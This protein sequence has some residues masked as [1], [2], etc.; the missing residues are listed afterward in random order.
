MQNYMMSNNYSN[1]TVFVAPLAIALW[2]FIQ[3]N[4]F[5]ATVVVISSQEDNETTKEISS[6]KGMANHNSN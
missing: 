3:R 6:Q 4:V 1:N 2:V 5:P